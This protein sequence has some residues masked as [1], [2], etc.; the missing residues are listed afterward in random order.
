MAEKITYPEY[1]K[2][3]PLL[4]KNLMKRPLFCARMMRP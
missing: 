2:H 3:Y 4:V 1:S